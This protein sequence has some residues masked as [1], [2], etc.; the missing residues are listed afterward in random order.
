ML[1]IR[2]AN[3]PGEIRAFFSLSKACGYFGEEIKYLKL[4]A[5]PSVNPLRA[6]GPLKYLSVYR[7]G[8]IVFRALAGSDEYFKE[9]SGKRIGYFSLFDGYRDAEAARLIL[10]KIMTLQRE[11]KNV[12]V[13]GPVSPDG[14]GF[15]HGLGETDA[16]NRRGVMTGNGSEWSIEALKDYGFSEM[17]ADNAYLLTIP[18]TDRYK[19]YASFSKEKFGLTVLPM[20]PGIFREKWKEAIASLSKEEERSDTYRYLEKIRPMISRKHSFLCFSGEKCL[21]YLIVLK[22][23]LSRLRACTVFTERDGFSPPVTVCLLS[24][25][26]S[27]CIEKGVREAEGSVIREDNLRSNLQISALG[28]HEKRRYVRCIKKVL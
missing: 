17:E 8:E 10:D 20:K 5:C 11:W 13:I 25:F 9:K 24:G 22:G 27:S 19:K 26:L 12:E 14:S 21:G 18:E 23:A 6:N 3:T 1:E 2:E 16:G 28:T 15:F 7:D 4:F